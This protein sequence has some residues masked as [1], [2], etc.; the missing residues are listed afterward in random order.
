MLADITHD[1]RVDV[2]AVWE[3]SELLTQKKLDE[4]QTTRSQRAL[5]GRLR[6]IGYMVQEA[7]PLIL[8]GESY[9]EKLDLAFLDRLATTA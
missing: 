5:A 9:L 1:L 6:R 4:E 2:I 8:A 3:F 7:F